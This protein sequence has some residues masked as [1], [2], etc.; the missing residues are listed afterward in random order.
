MAP[1]SVRNPIPFSAVSTLYNVVHMSTIGP[2]MV[3]V[4]VEGIVEGEEALRSDC[5]QVIG[6]RPNLTSFL[7]AGRAKLE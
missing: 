3:L 7:E 4:A 5:V 6:T 1:S 2:K